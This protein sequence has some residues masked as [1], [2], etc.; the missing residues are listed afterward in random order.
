MIDALGG[1]D[2]DVPQ[3]MNYDDP[4]QDLHIHLKKGFQHLDGDKAEQL[5]RFRRYPTG[6]IKRVEVQQDFMKAL[7]DQKLNPTIIASLPE[8]FNVWTENIRMSFKGDDI[9]RYSGNLLK[10][11]S[12]NIKAYLLPG[13]ADGEHYGASYWVADMDE[14]KKLV[15]GTFG[16]D[17]SNIT[18]H[19]SDGKSASKDV[20]KTTTSQPKPKAT[21]EKTETEEEDDEKPKS[22]EKDKSDT[23]DKDKSKSEDKDK[24]KSE[25]KDKPKANEEENS[26]SKNK[27]TEQK[28]EDEPKTGESGSKRPVANDED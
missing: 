15:E 2:F 10:L 11:R 22:G 12:E 18:I 9:I 26:D 17:A 27:D 6:D 5:V 4:V 25:G 7:A 3:N 28:S 19:S 1:V 14:V 23:S 24:P 8:L 13:V 21:E 20:K 16:Y